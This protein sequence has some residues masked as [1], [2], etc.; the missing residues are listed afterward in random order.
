MQITKR[1][2]LSKIVRLFNLLGWLA[3]VIVIVKV[4]MQDLWLESL[5]C[6]SVLPQLFQDLWTQFRGN[7]A[8]IPTICI[9]RWL[10]M[11]ES[12]NWQLHGFADASQQAYAAV[13]YAVVP[14]R[15]F[16]LLTAKTKIAPTKVQSLPRLELCAATFLVRLVPHILNAAQQPP[17][18]THV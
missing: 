2:I 14:G 6:D 17:K 16:L 4:I 15:A 1:T 3:P 18:A 7:L 10:G 13:F 12:D 11:F 9:P 5:D 8:E